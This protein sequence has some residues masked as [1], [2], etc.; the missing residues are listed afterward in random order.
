MVPGFQSA[1]ND[2]LAYLRTKFCENDV[3]K[4][5]QDKC[6]VDYTKPECL[7]KKPYEIAKLCPQDMFPSCK[8]VTYFDVIVQSA[9]LQMDY[10]MYTGCVNYFAE[11]LGKLCG[12][13]MACLPTVDSVENL[14]SLPD[15]DTKLA[16]LRSVVIADSDSAV[17]EFFKQLEKDKTVIAC[18][19]SQSGDKSK[20]LRDKESLGTNVFNAARLVAKMS[21]ENRNLRALD[22]KIAELTRKADVE[23]AR[24]VCLNTYKVETPDKSKSNYMYIKSVSF[25]PDLRNCHVC[26]MQQVCETGGES[27]WTSALK[28]ASGGLAAGAS[29]GTMVSPGWGTAIVGLGVAAIAGFAGYKSG[30]KED[31]CQQIESCG[32]INM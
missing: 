17:E 24:K 29:A 16:D 1:V 26:R 21:A 8:N 22:S 12:T 25:E 19:D 15:A 14:A 6:G 9:M 2:K 31:F 20:R 28:A 11:Q 27:E 18:A 5:L 7:G 30:G 32:D 13:D 4:C 23:E 3:D 10:Q